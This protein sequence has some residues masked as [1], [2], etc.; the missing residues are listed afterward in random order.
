MVPADRGRYED[1][2]HQKQVGCGLL[3]GLSLGLG[4]KR[5]WASFAASL[6]PLDV[7]P[8]SGPKGRWIP[9]CQPFE[10]LSL[11]VITLWVSCTWARLVFS[12]G[13]F[14]SQVQ[15]L[16][17]GVSTVGFKLLLYQGEVWV[18]SP[19]LSESLCSRWSLWW[20]LCPSLFY[21]LWC[22]PSLIS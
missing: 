13:G 14:I 17:V 21:S 19:L 20:Q 12:F 7:Q 1:G 10:S 6:P 9:S 15:V 11:I 3:G 5:G 4:F 18:L 8:L 2:G 22:G 16:K